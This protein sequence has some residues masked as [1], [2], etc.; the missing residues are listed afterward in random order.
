MLSPRALVLTNE[1][2]TTKTVTTG[3]KGGKVM[4]GINNYSKKRSLTFKILLERLQTRKL[5]LLALLKI[6]LTLIRAK[7]EPDLTL[8]AL[9]T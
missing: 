8:T 4:N 3:P 1:P 6:I 5:Y 7:L 9:S 2:Q